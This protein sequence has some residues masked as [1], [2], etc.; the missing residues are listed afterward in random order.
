M[1]ELEGAGVKDS[2]KWWSDGWESAKKG[3]EELRK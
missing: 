2:V 1:K 3:I